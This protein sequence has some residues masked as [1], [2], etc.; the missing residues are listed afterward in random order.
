MDENEQFR[1]DEDTKWFGVRS[2]GIASM[3]TSYIIETSRMRDFLE[4]TISSRGQPNPKLQFPIRCLSYLGAHYASVTPENVESPVSA[5]TTT[6]KGQPT[7]GEVNLYPELSTTGTTIPIFLADCEGITGGEP[8]AKRFQNT[9]FDTQKPRRKK[10]RIRAKLGRSEVVKDLYP[11]LLYTLSDV[12]CY[13]VSEPSWQDVLENLLEW[14]TTGAQHTINQAA[15]PALIIILNIEDR[16]ISNEWIL[17]R[18]WDVHSEKD[19]PDPVTQ[20]VFNIIKAFKAHKN[21]REIKNPKRACQYKVEAKDESDPDYELN[22]IL[23]DLRRSYSRI[24]VHYIPRT[25]VRTIDN[26]DLL[27]QQI[28]TLRERI[29]AYSN[30]I[31]GLRAASLTQ[32]NSRQF[33][34]MTDYAFSHFCRDP[35]EP[36][37]FGLFQQLTAVPD[38]VETH[39]FLV[40]SN[41][42][43]KNIQ[44]YCQNAIRNFLDVYMPCSYIHDET[45]DLKVRCSNTRTGHTKGHQGPFGLFLTDGPFETGGIDEKSFMQSVED[46]LQALAMNTNMDPGSGRGTW[47]SQVDKEHKKN[48]E[49]LRNCGAYPNAK[50]SKSYDPDI[51]SDTYE[52]LSLIR[53]NV[54]VIL[55]ST[56]RVVESK[57]F[58]AGRFC[59]GCLFRK[60]E[61]ALPCSHIICANCLRENMSTDSIYESMATAILK[62][63]IIC[64]DDNLS[65][66]DGWPFTVPIRP[67]L[68]NPRVLSLDGGGVRGIMQ[69][70]MLE[71]LESLIGLGL[72]IGRFFD[73]MVG[74]SGGGITALGIGIQ[75]LS[76]SKCLKRFKKISKK[77]FVSKPGMNIPGLKRISMFFRG[78]V[79]YVSSFEKVLEKKFRQG[80]PTGVFGLKN[81]CRVAVTTTVGTDTCLIA[82]YNRGGTKKYLESLTTLWTAARCTSAA[83]TYFDPVSHEG[84]TCQDGGLNVNNPVQLAYQESQVIWGDNTRHDLILS[85]G[86]GKASHPQPEPTSTWLVPAPLLDLWKS[87]LSTMSGEDGW[88]TFFESQTSN[89]KARCKRLNVKLPGEYEPAM[90]AVGEIENMEAIARN[91]NEPYTKSLLTPYEPILGNC[92]ENKLEIIADIMRAGQ[93]FF[94]LESL[95]YPSSD[96]KNFVIGGRLRCLLGL[97]EIKNLKKLLARTSHFRINQAFDLKIPTSVDTLTGFNLPINFEHEDPKSP[98]RIDVSFG[99]TYQTAISGF[100]KD[101]RE[102]QEYDDK[103]ILNLNEAPNPPRESADT[104]INGEATNIAGGVSFADVKEESSTSAAISLSNI[105]QGDDSQSENELSIVGTPDSE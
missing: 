89:V 26:P 80:Q 11:R 103:V 56:L 45:F 7:T 86:S 58:I 68:T 59:Y 53:S 24:Q 17:P 66:R 57:P 91:Y 34:I 92:T 21:D 39:I 69:L 10:Y 84:S 52:V 20:Y 48:I 6:Q 3:K 65:N 5:C 93:Y 50:A 16:K 25:G 55:D 13:V 9:W 61:Y 22:G 60:P 42:F 51:G 102:L 83:P 98:V 88:N 30:F 37:D 31:Q 40:K 70:V 85:L 27:F 67:D 99:G 100:P 8:I 87:F 41:V 73:L 28:E 1:T 79:Y 94:Q 12:V 47:K 46:K 77:G 36:F 64:G 43:D 35:E 62:N 23:T 75:G 81:H 97:T 38:S 49:A 2:E 15:L 4:A 19:N 72:P 32:F 33:I 90:D 105:L 74:T 14:S 96:N 101:L 104:A 63:C 76:A 95:K 71:R 44:K 54:E 18:D 29:L 78:S 82:N